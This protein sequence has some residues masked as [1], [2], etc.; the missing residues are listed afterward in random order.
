MSQLSKFCKIHLVSEQEDVI[1]FFTNL[2]EVMGNFSVEREFLHESY[3]CN[4][5]V[6]L[7]ARMLESVSSSFYNKIKEK[8]YVI[9]CLV[10]ITISCATRNYIDNKFKYAIPFPIKRE[11]FI[12]YYKEINYSN[13]HINEKIDE[14]D[15]LIYTKKETFW[16]YFIG[17]SN[18][19][20]KLRTE[21]EEVAKSD[22]PV[23][24]MG[25]TGTGK[26]TGAYVIHNLSKRKQKKIQA[27]NISTVVD[28]LASSTF[29]GTEKGAYTDAVFKE[30]LF[31]LADKSTLFLDEI[32]LATPAIQ[33]MLLTVLGSGVIQKVGSDN[34]VKVDVRL[35]TATNAKLDRMVE[36][37]LFR[38]DLF[39][40]IAANII[41]FPALRERKEDIPDIVKAYLW[42]RQKDISEEAME[43]L[44]EYSWPGNIRELHNCLERAV[45][46]SREDK[47]SVK[48]VK[49]GV[50]NPET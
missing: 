39:F 37:G 41:I 43:K 18:L 34:F 31:S 2:M 26:T 47:I 24:L 45:T 19:I 8:N 28:S 14:N 1:N 35:I 13:D 36:E 7:D 30:G 6:I 29:F 46:T 48:N 33:A 5:L 16:G 32:G 50:L 38:A 42:K 11:L 40:R 21:I 17:K 10:P 49:F 25:E 27:L 12:N 4:S 20:K 3:S 44:Y 9:L 15:D 22:K 23:L